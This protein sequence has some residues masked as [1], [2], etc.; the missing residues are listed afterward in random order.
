MEDEAMKQRT[1]WAR[2]QGTGG[3]LRGAM[4]LAA[5]VLVGTLMPA[6]CADDSRT[7]LTQ[8]GDAGGETDGSMGAGTFDRG[9]VLVRTAPGVDVEELNGYYGT[10]TGGQLEPERVYLLECPRGKTV[11]DLLPEMSRNPRVEAA[12]PNYRMQA[13]EAEGRRSGSIAF[14]DNDRGTTAVADQSALLRIRAA[15][16]QAYA[17]G[18]GVLVAVLDTGVDARHPLLASRLAPGGADF[19]DGDEDPTDVPDGKDSD[20]DGLVD[21]AFGH[22]TAV[23]GLILSVAPEARILPI[24]ILDSDGIGTAF[25][26]ARG[27]SLADSRGADVVN[28]SFGMGRPSRIVSDLIDRVHDRGAIVIASAGN[29]NVGEPPQV[30][31]GSPLVIGVAATDSLDR[32]ADFSNFGSWVS[33]SAPGVGLLSPAPHGRYALWSGTSFSAALVSGEAALLMSSSAAEDGAHLPRTIRDTAVPLAEVDPAFGSQLGA[34]RIDVL[35]AVRA[36]G[37]IG[38][39]DIELGRASKTSPGE[40]NALESRR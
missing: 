31:G 12:E 4:P 7:S 20:G 35:S 24:R 26:V 29:R 33:V 37:G 40:P 5:L 17:R 14:A 18:S 6:G 16:A 13:P 36:N 21:E 22:G 39:A 32:K 28:M 15:E 25:D 8:P 19:V 34:G 27:I 30:P 23:A 3:R 10:W 1:S 11:D 38:D 2:R 9:E